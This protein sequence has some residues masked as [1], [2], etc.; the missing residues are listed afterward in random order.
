MIPVLSREQVRAFDRA[1][2]DDCHVQS[3]GLMENAGRG[4]VDAIAR[5]WPDR[6]LSG[7][8][9]V[10]VAGPGN[11][12]GDGFVVA[13]HLVT[14]GATVDVFV[15]GITSKIQGDAHAHFEAMEG[16]GVVAHEVTGDLSALR[17]AMAAATL[18]VDA[19]FGTG[20]SRPVEGREA[21]ILEAIQQ[22][23]RPIAALDVPSGLDA[24]TGMPLGVA[25]H[26]D[27]TVTFAAHKLGLLTPHGARSAG[28]IVL[29]DIGVPARLIERV[30][31]AA[32]LLERSDV[33]RLLPP[34]AS[35]IHK[36]AAG[37][38]VVFA[39][40]PGHLGAAVM[41]AHGAFRAGAGL[42]TIASW[43]ETA[44]ALD[45][46]VVEVM[47]ARLSR[48]D[49]ARSV[50]D[51][52]ARAK[53]VVMGPGFGRDEA[54]RT[55]VRYI[56]SKWEGPSVVDAD[57]LAMFA[58]DAEVF[59]S[60]KGAAVLTPHPGE[61]GVLLGSSAKEVE[62]DRFTALASCVERARSVTVLK[63]EHTLIGAPDERPVINGS[64]N[65]ALATAGSGDVLAGT[66]GALACTLD[67]FE[68]A[69]AG[70]HLHGLAAEAWSRRNG[71]RGLLAHEIGDEY[72]GV[73]AGLCQEID[74]A[75]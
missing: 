46:R 68:A 60:S 47:T 3:V 14:R 57:A 29:A 51:V 34:R 30:G 9:V 2:I 40:S 28:K 55:V 69:F 50:D 37:H 62:A 49:L 64:G 17:D 15:T 12:G 45:G 26:A 66:I 58:D 61:L 41:C 23:K 39:G 19:V 31:H 8:R 27:L 1:C 7:A 44:D 33:A 38:V 13:R 16:L 67:P 59:A 52:L 11:N 35:G 42:V 70:V 48:D 56:L 5:H 53:V 24:D 21:S 10:V 25:L 4:A 20:L 36:N 6:P 43:P 54:A 22:A 72:P 74:R 73:I 71:D 32:S 75:P 18:V 65:S 63:G